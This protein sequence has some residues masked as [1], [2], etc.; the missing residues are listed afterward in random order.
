MLRSVRLTCLL[1]LAAVQP[2]AAADMPPSF[3]DLVEHLSPA[4][5]N[6]STTQKLKSAGVPMLEFHGMPEGEQFA[7]FKEFFE[8]FGERFGGMPGSG[9]PQER[10]VRSLGSGF[11]IDPT[12]Y[13]VTNNHVVAEADEVTVTFQDDTKYEAKIVG[14]DPKTDLALIKVEAK[15]KLPYVRFGESD[16]MRVGDWV[17]AIGNPFGLGGSVSAGIISARSR[18]INAGPFDDFIQTDAAINRGNSGGPLFN[19]AGEVIGVNSAIFSPS[20]GNI[21]IGFA[22]PSSLAE[23]VLGQLKEY[24]RT[25]RGWLGVKIQHVTEEIADSLNLDSARGALVLEVNE[26]SPAEKGGVIS[27]DVILSFNN[28]P[29]NEMRKLPRLVAETKVGATVDVTVWRNDKEKDLKVTLGE[30]EEGE[31]AIAAD[32]EGKGSAPVPES[33]SEEYLGLRLATLSRSL[34]KELSIDEPKTGVLVLAVEAGTVGDESGLRRYDIVT[35][36]NQQ[37]V[38]SVKDLKSAIESARKE[39]KKHALLR[40]I[41]SKNGMFVTMPVEGK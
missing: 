13:I 14:R 28:Q 34:R 22:I 39:G 6:I 33:K 8:Q 25:H 20:G 24:G 36:A 27:G 31:E 10:D 18:N 3:A 1:I 32:E 29:V 30:M 38:E 7:P 35:E 21:G 40:I 26:G 19:A 16:D 41:R 9:Q 5:V 23:P 11:V 2:A 37:K 12:G 15:K 17:I 4:V